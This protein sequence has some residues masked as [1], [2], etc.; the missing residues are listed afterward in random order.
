MPSALH[1][2]HPRN[3]AAETADSQHPHP[4][5]K[6]LRIL[7][8]AT[9][10]RLGGMLL[11]GLVGIEELEITLIEVQ[12]VAAGM[13]RLRDEIFDAVILPHE[14]DGLDAVAFTQAMRA[15]GAEEAVIVIG[16]GNE[17]DMA[18]ACY[19]AGGDAYVC[20]QTATLAH[21]IWVVARA[22]ERQQLMRQVRRLSQAEESRLAA[23]HSEA[24]RLLG[25]LAE[26][27][28]GDDGALFNAGDEHPLPDELISHYQQLL[29]AYVIMGS[30]HLRREVCHLAELLARAGISGRQLLQLHLYV[31]EDTL[32]GLGNRSSR[33]VFNRADLLGLEVMTRLA[34]CYRRQYRERQT[35]PRQQFLP[36]FDAL[37]SPMV[38][39]H[40]SH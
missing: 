39:Q 35:P 24:R 16:H 31:L 5:P 21:L 13:A 7:Y 2:T 29:R 17:A 11:D 33:H 12:G 37:A 9:H 38:K 40:G 20:E 32:A 1:L 27:A 18:V 10:R 6:R 4:V 23:E 15:G 25:E 36:G 34:D 14:P 8:V 30:G 3:S 26:L 22:A 28:V 19:Q